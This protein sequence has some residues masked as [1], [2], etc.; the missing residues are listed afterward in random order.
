M[1]ILNLATREKQDEI[2]G[3]LQF[4]NGQ[5]VIST[6]RGSGLQWGTVVDVEGKGQ[7]ISVNQQATSPNS[8]LEIT[9]DWVVIHSDEETFCGDG[10][11]FAL[12]LYD[13][14]ESLIVRHRANV[15]SG[16][17]VNTMVVF[18]LV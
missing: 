11:A 12:L 16:Q 17:I 13:F 3:K 4:I 15:S 8:R 5:K 6:G 2:L 10:N 7:L 9:I 18:S 1:E 14:E